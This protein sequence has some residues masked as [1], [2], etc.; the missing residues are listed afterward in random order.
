MKDDHSIYN[1]FTSRIVL[2]FLLIESTF[3][4]ILKYFEWHHGGVRINISIIYAVFFL[5]L[6]GILIVRLSVWKK[7][8]MHKDIFLAASLLFLIAVIVIASYPSI[9]SANI[10]RIQEYYLFYFSSTIIRSFLYFFS[11]FY[12]L[13]FLEKKRFVRL[14]LISWG[15]YT[16]VIFAFSVMK[17]G[18]LDAT[19]FALNGNH[20]YLMMADAYALLSII[21]IVSQV[22]L[23]RKS[24]FIL[25][26]ILALFLLKSRASMYAFVFV[27]FATLVRFDKR[28]IWGVCIALLLGLWQLD[29]LESIRSVANHRMFRVLIGE[30]NSATMRSDIM[31]IG[32]EGIKQH[33]F[34][35]QF[36]GDVLQK[37]KTGNYIHNILSYWRQ[38]GL[39]PFVLLV[40]LIFKNYTN[41]IYA[42]LTHG[43]NPRLDFIFFYGFY[44]L[45][46]VLFARS[47]MYPSIWIIFSAVP[48]YFNTQR[49]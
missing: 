20:N 29:V 31:S 5:L 12:L 48:V 4:P 43:W 17:G 24:I 33:W 47:F 2:A 6:I 26:S 27:S 39:I 11:G 1:L 15:V 45:A 9:V 49:K 41:L 10:H 36:M 34:L 8:K 19:L 44:V 30:D 14:I 7:F 18:I 21:L 40:Y 22:T 25:I 3:K 35:G 23:S 13:Q 16:A 38:F 37:E 28:F 46:L 32:L 42:V